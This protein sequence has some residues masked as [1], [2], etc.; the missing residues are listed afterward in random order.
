MYYSKT[1]VWNKVMPTSLKKCKIIEKK[2][3]KKK[4]YRKNA[5]IYMYI[6]RSV[7]YVCGDKF[8]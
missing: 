8:C 1:V 4:Q 3:T 6:D 5:L 7:L 2:K